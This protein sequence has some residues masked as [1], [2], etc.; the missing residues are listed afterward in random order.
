MSFVGTE[1]EASSVLQTLQK[2]AEKPD[3]TLQFNYASEAL[4]NSFFLSLLVSCH[5]T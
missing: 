1:S 3:E 2:T 4:N 5:S